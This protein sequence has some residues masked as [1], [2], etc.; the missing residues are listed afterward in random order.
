VCVCV[1]HYFLRVNFLLHER[2]VRSIILL[3]CRWAA[4]LSSVYHILLCLSSWLHHQP[5]GTYVSTTHV[6]QVLN[7]LNFFTY[8]A[9][10]WWL[11]FIVYIF[12]SLTS[13]LCSLSIL[14]FCGKL[15][16]NNHYYYYTPFNGVFSRTTWVSRYQNGKTSLD[17]NEARDDGVLGCSGISWTICKHSAPRSRQITTPTP[18]HS[19]FTG[20]KVVCK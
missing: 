11:N 6:P 13:S 8:I 15:S 17:L 2:I 18:H 7:M 4:K 10:T 9:K 14:L 1:C 5:I 3:C 12:N 20:G 16:T 19:I